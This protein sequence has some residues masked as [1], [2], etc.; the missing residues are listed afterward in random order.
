MNLNGKRALVT[1]ASRGI[2]RAIALRL[3]AEGADLGLGYLQNR[4]LAEEVRAQVEALGRNAVLLEGDLRAPDVCRDVVRQCA[5]KLGG[6]EVLVSNAAIGAH[7]EAMRLRSSHWDLTL[8]SS[9]RPLLLLTQAAAPLLEAAGGGSIVAISSMGSRRVVPGYAAMGSAKAVVETLVR[10]LAV[11]L[12]PRGIRV[13]CVAGGLVRTD[14]ISYLKDGE[15]IL[16]EVAAHTPMG[17]VGR[18][19]DLAAVVAFLLSQDAGW[20]CGQTIVADGGLSLR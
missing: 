15:H 5:Q 8:E 19:E 20:I 3:A 18:P 10:Y 16:A 17:R 9:A 6:L 12:A 7:R 2:G 1:G 13:N 4:A 11:E 14:A